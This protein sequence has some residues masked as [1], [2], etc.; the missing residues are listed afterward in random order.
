MQTSHL[1]PA[2]TL[3]LVALFHLALLYAWQSGVWK[4]AR[5]APEQ[6]ALLYM[7]LRTLAPA[8]AGAP[9][10]QPAAI[11]P[12]PKRSN[13]A[14]VRTP[15]A[16][17]TMVAPPEPAA[18]GPAPASAAPALD[19]EG[20]HLA[21]RAYER[22]RKPGEIEL[23]QRQQQHALT[24]EEKF[25]NGVKKAQ[26]ADCRKAYAGAGLLAVVPLA[27]SSVMDTGCNW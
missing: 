25:G 4:R 24:T 19:L 20:L 21:A 5:T 1:R 12:T 18:P 10:A 14:P 8:T 16:A 6:A 27:L 15:A 22:T 2:A 11:A 13:R 7:E 17:L 23:L 26:R 3:L 9:A